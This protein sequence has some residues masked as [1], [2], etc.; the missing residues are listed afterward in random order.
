MPKDTPAELM[1]TDTAEA[2]LTIARQLQT[3]M[4]WVKNIADFPFLEHP[5]VERLTRSTNLLYYLGPILAAFFWEER[6]RRRRRRH[7]FAD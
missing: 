1:R 6:R 5:G 3:R 7:P 4:D 2:S